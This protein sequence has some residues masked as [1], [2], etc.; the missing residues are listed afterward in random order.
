M[1]TLQVRVWAQNAAVGVS[2]WA[3]ET[4]GIWQDKSGLTTQRMDNEVRERV[5]EITHFMSIINKQGA[6]PEECN[7]LIDHCVTRISELESKRPLWKRYMADKNNLNGQKLKAALDEF[8]E[9]GLPQRKNRLQETPAKTRKLLHIGMYFIAP[10]LLLLLLMMCR[11]RRR[12][13]RNLGSQVFD[14]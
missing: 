10:M 3:A 12:R 8:E 7:L 2:Q 5:W 1:P 13:G 11:S 9:V 4:M 14:D 6:G